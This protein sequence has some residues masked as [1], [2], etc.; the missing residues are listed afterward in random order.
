M[1]LVIGADHLITLKKQLYSLYDTFN[2]NTLLPQKKKMA[3]LNYC[4]SSFGYRNWDDFQ[5][6]T[7]GHK[8]NNTTKVFT[9]VNIDYIAR[10]L[11]FSFGTDEATTDLIKA[12]IVKV[13][14]IEEQIEF[15]DCVLPTLDEEPMV[16]EL[17][18]GPKSYH[19]M[20]L[21]EYLWPY[22][23]RTLKDGP[24]E[25]SKYMASQRK[26]LSKEEISK[27]GLDVYAKKGITANSL[28]KGLIDQ[29]Y[30][31]NE[32]ERLTISDRGDWLC[33]S[34]FTSDYDEEWLKWFSSFQRLYKDIPHKSISDD[35]TL[36]INAYRN[37]QTPES[38]IELFGWGRL[39]TDAFKAIKSEVQSLKLDNELAI[40]HIHP[41]LYLSSSDYGTK[42]KDVTL[43]LSST[44]IDIDNATFKLNKPY[45]NKSYIGASTSKN[46]NGIFLSIPPGIDDVNILMKW[47]LPS[48][49]MVEHRLNLTLIKSNIK[50]EHFFSVDVQ[51]YKG[52]EAAVMVAPRSIYAL[53]EYF[54]PVDDETLEEAISRHERF[55]SQINSLARDKIS[56]SISETLQLEYF[57]FLEGWMLSK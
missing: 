4:A 28:F 27:R 54:R 56:C 13:L 40:L 1:Q 23:N 26:G 18:L 5:R 52:D 39:Y 34:T 46:V 49:F 32:E 9:P 20:M 10:S 15:K 55:G 7:L 57:P 24:I 48:G 12:C 11:R 17:E 53:N 35:W 33:R 44:D 19:E 42:A 21:L 29:G 3:F 47:K 41:T 37:G 45:P 2:T 25:Y 16:I 50:P 31:N 22:C 43:H 38:A 30:L 8:S 36:Y 51:S 14:S 6:T